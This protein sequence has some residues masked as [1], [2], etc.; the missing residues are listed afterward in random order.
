MV[1]IVNSISCKNRHCWQSIFTYVNIQ[2]VH[3]LFLVCGLQPPPA[4]CLLSRFFWSFPDVQVE[5]HQTHSSVMKSDFIQPSFLQVDPQNFSHFDFSFERMQ[6]YFPLSVRFNNVSLRLCLRALR[7][8]RACVA[9]LLE[10]Q[11][12]LKVPSLPWPAR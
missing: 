7:Q 12:S 4:Q 10:K 3:T 2:Q 11:D 9:T 6:Y 1:S 5:P 8:D